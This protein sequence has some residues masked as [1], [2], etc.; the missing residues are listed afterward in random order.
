MCVCDLEGPCRTLDLTDL[1]S[2]AGAV[3]EKE[4][5][6]ERERE[7]ER[8]GRDNHRQNNRLLV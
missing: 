1:L 3:V 2:S 4:G 7:R 8:E 6:R 5:E